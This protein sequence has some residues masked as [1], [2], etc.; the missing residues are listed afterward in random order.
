MTTS[1]RQAVLDCEAALEDLREATGL[2][3]RT[4]WVAAV[5]LLKIVE[6]VLWKID[7]QRSPELRAAIRAEYE[8]LAEDQPPIFGEFIRG[9]RRR[10]LHFY[11]FRAGQSVTVRPGGLWFNLGTGESGSTASGPTTYE[12]VMRGGPFAGQ[13]PRDV[14]QQAIEWWRAYLDRVAARVAKP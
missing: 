9:E 2:R 6:D 8:R 13:D 12:H 14:V 1:A 10:A 4:R 5:A 7:A 11:E 3:W